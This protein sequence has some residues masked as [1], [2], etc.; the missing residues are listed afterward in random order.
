MDALGHGLGEAS[1]ALHQLPHVHSSDV[2][3]QVQPQQQH[4][5]GAWPD[6]RRKL[7]DDGRH[8]FGCEICGERFT[9]FENLKRHKRNHDATSVEQCPC[10]KVKCKRPDLLK[11]HVKKFHPQEMERLY[12]KPVPGVPMAPQEQFATTDAAQTLTSLAMPAPV[13]PALQLQHEHNMLINNLHGFVPTIMQ[14]SSNDLLDRLPEMPFTEQQLEEFTALYFQ[15]FHAAF[16]VLHQPTFAKHFEETP[17]LLLPVA[18]IGALYTQDL[19][20]QKK[21]LSVWMNLVSIIKSYDLEDSRTDPIALSLAALLLCYFGIFFGDEQTHTAALELHASRIFQQRRLG[22]KEGPVSAMDEQATVDENWQTFLA[23]E[24]RLRLLFGMQ[25]LDMQ[26]NT[27]FGTP[28]LLM[29]H[30]LP[31]DMPCPE[32]QW[33]APTAEAWDT[34]AKISTDGWT[35]AKL[36]VEPLHRPIDTCQGPPAL[37]GFRG[38]FLV[39]RMRKEIY[40]FSALATRFRVQRTHEC[41][42]SSIDDAFE[43]DYYAKLC[44]RFKERIEE[45]GDLMRTQD[46]AATQQAFWDAWHLSHLQIG[47]VSALRLTQE[48]PF[49]LLHQDSRRELHD[50]QFPLNCPVSLSLRDTVTSLLKHCLL[51]PPSLCAAGESLLDDPAA[52]ITEAELHLT[53]FVQRLASWQ[54]LASQRGRMEDPV[55]SYILL[56]GCMACW[57]LLQVADDLKVL[58]ATKKPEKGL[59]I[60]PE[61]R[62]QSA[63]LEKKVGKIFASFVGTGS[64]RAKKFVQLMVEKTRDM[65]AWQFGEY[66]DKALQTTTAQE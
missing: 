53:W 59:K 21:A 43:S 31:K 48:G 4:D 46:P 17:W 33:D 19:S 55:S 56:T 30:E 58:V 60:K 29:I 38:L 44:H 41:D 13:D 3:D 6:K 27:I 1:H 20:Y 50:E 7:A 66:V 2:L 54:P 11:R 24:T 28:S 42:N 39:H 10:C 22:F 62:K 25:L 15:H 9:R 64:D 63:A 23:R 12:P 57:H 35:T 52:S 45:M 32:V 5:E 37:L 16:P 34:T 40:D 14:P 47:A 26:I 51:Q 36:M 8:L 18:C 49:C 65:R 61:Q